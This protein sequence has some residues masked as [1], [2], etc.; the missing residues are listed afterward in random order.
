MNTAYPIPRKALPTALL[1]CALLVLALGGCNTVAGLG[2]DVEAAG[3]AVE[4][5][6]EEEK[7]Y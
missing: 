1:A 4:Q 2:E 7:G 6:A 3:G 5:K